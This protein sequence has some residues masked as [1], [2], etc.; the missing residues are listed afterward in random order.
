MEGPGTLVAQIIYAKHRELHRQG[1]FAARQAPQGHDHPQAQQAHGGN[2]AHKGGGRGRGQ[3]T[4]LHKHGGLLGDA[5][6]SATAAERTRSAPVLSSGGFER[7]IITRLGK[8]SVRRK[9]CGARVNKVPDTARTGVEALAAATTDTAQGERPGRVHV[10][11]NPSTVGTPRPNRGKGAAAIII[12]I[13]P[14]NIRPG[15]ISRQRQ[16]AKG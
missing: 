7:G 5:V 8:G 16:A 10:A 11:V 1:I 3:R 2:V 14:L 4:P 15:N 9:T 13:Q 12:N 6:I